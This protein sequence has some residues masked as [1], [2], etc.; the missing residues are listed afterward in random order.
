MSFA[1]IQ[2]FFFFGLLSGTTVLFIYMLGGYLVT[3]LW[4]VVIALV[5]YPVYEYLKT[6]F[7]GRASAAALSTV[8]L[9]VLVVLIPLISVGG[10]VVSESLALYDTLTQE[11]GSGDSPGLLASV[12][13]VTS[14]L[15]PYGI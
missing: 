8:L 7:K 2:K 1:T 14:Y 11:D 3:V 4:A 6:A 13:T 10:M 9:V 12:S 15:E 5:F